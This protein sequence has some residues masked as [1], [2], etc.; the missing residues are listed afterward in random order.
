MADHFLPQA[1]KNHCDI[2]NSCERAW[3]RP[4]ESCGE[5]DLPLTLYVGAS[6]RKVHALPGTFD[7]LPC[8]RNFQTP[9]YL[10]DCCG[11][12][13]CLKTVLFTPIH[14]LRAARWRRIRSITIER[15]R[16][17]RTKIR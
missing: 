16:A 15:L 6:G 9:A 8:G 1:V 5:A 13:L 10:L 4:P 14:S 3:D 17:E 11:V 7:M 12:A 2:F